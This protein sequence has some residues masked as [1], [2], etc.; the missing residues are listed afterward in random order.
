ML[1]SKQAS[2][3][4]KNLSLGR[5]HILCLKKTKEISEFFCFDNKLLK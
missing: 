4:D 5:E 1:P 2:E 3:S